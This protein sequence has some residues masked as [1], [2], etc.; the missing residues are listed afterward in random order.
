MKYKLKK[1]QFG[2]HYVDPIPSEEELSHYYAQQYYQ[3]SKASTYSQSY[4]K[5]ELQGIKI[6]AYVSNYV[7]Q[8]HVFNNKKLLLDIGCGE[9]FFMDIF[10]GFGWD[11][12]GTDY[13]IAGATRHNPHLIE[14][15]LVGKLETVLENFINKKKYFNLINLGNILEHVT[16]PINLLE[17]CHQLLEKDGVLRVKVPNDLS[18]LQSVLEKKKLTNSDWFCPPDHLSYFN[19]KNIKETLMKSNFSILKVLGDFP[20]EFYL[21]N[22]HSN[23]VLN[24]IGKEAHKART[25]ITNLIWEKG[26]ESYIKWSEGLASAE[27]SRSCITFSIKTK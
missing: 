22:K 26:I 4:S 19:F 8:D 24:D 14:K 18:E 25:T 9:G 20:I 2:F 27:I 10:H 15:I 5:E 11:V 12:I 23:Y 1:H 6:D 13:S 16:N 3:E 7:V 17:T 21:L